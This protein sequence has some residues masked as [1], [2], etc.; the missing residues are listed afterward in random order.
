MRATGVVAPD[1]VPGAARQL[2][3]KW[4]GRA[5]SV[6]ATR[7]LMEDDDAV[8]EAFMCPITLESTILLSPRAQLCIRYCSNKQQLEQMVDPVVTRDSLRKSMEQR[9]DETIDPLLRRCFERRPALRPTAAD[10]ADAF[11]REGVTTLSTSR[12]RGAIVMLRANVTL[13]RRL[14]DQEAITDDVT[15]VNLRLK[16]ENARLQRELENMRRQY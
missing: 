15:R 11:V 7:A 9:R 5:R 6:D 14:E 2:C 13:A 10:L 16:Q 3:C 12:S 4:R 1:C 8:P